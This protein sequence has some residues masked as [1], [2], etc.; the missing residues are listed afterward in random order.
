MAPLYSTGSESSV[1]WISVTQEKETKLTHDIYLFRSRVMLVYL[2]W[3]LSPDGWTWVDWVVGTG[4]LISMQRTLLTLKA[5]TCRLSV[6]NSQWSPAATPWCCWC[7][8]R[9][10]LSALVWTLTHSERR[11][12][13]NSRLVIFSVISP[14]PHFSQ[15]YERTGG[16][17]TDGC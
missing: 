1:H 6:S 7:G 17:T 13:L 10:S 2:S 9:V 5:Q 15:P 3:D 4:R 12:F 8:Q 14:S 16:C 11:V